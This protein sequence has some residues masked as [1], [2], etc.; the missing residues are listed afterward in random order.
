MTWEGLLGHGDQYLWWT[1]LLLAALVEA[2]QRRMCVYFQAGSKAVCHRGAHGI[3][4]SNP[5]TGTAP[6]V[7][8]EAL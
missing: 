7:S 3:L 5:K 1:P 6:I 2:V 4:A 8:N